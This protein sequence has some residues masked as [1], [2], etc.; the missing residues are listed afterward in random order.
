MTASI[1]AAF[2]PPPGPGWVQF[3]AARPRRAGLLG[4]LRGAG[5][6]E[7]LTAW[8]AATAA[9]LPGPQTDPGLAGSYADTLADLAASARK[10]GLLLGYA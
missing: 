1:S 3:P 4:T 5:H 6:D 8:A 2:D 9:G 7:D 10:R